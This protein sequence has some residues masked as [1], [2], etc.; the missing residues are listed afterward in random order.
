ML[1]ELYIADNILEN[2]NDISDAPSLIKIHARKNKIARFESF[3]KLGA[4]KYLNLR[5]N[6]IAKIE[7]IACIG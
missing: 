3:P 2:L 1:R 6:L 7:D 4:L 5:E